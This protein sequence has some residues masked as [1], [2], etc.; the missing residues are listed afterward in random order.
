MFRTIEDILQNTTDRIY[1]Q[2]TVLLPSFLA[3]T[4]VLF[5]AWIVACVVRWAIRRIFT[6]AALGRFL[7]ESGLQAMMGRYGERPPGELLSASAYWL[8]LFAGALSAVDVFGTSLTT[9]IVSTAVFLL[10]KLVIAGVLLMAG[11]WLA[12]FL[13]RHTLVWA[14]NEGLPYP[15]RWGGAVRVAI[16]FATIVVAADT[17]DFARHVFLAAFIIGVGGSALA[18]SLAFGLGGRDAAGRLLSPRQHTEDEHG[19]Q[20]V[21]HHL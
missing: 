10:P 18:A 17:L 21:W 19:E 8:I 15:R 12:R 20:G 3:A 9:E 7:S 16:S 13:G 14:L 11:F 1:Q 5:G 2:A 6:A 4:V